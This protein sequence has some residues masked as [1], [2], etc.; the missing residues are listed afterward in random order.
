MRAELT[1]GATNP[2]HNFLGLFPP[3]S[4]FANKTNPCMLIR[5][6]TQLLIDGSADEASGTSV[7]SK[8][9][10]YSASP[11]AQPPGMG[12]VTLGNGVLLCDPTISSCGVVPGNNT[13][14]KVVWNVCNEGNATS[15]AGTITL[16][17]MHDNMSESTQMSLP[18]L[19]SGACV[20][21]STQTLT[22]NSPGSTYNWDVYL[23]TRFLGG[24]SMTF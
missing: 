9:V 4:I 15:A 11:P 24:Q 2:L 3:R 1:N 7:F 8:P 20:Q 23:G 5:A 12:I 22:I 18:A 13:P 17:T 21:Q 19:A 14:F 6:T 16:Y 10:C